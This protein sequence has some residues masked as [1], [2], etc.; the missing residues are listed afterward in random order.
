MLDFGSG[1]KPLW[2]QVADIIRDKIKN[3]EYK[4]GEILPPEMKLVDE[5]GV[6]RVTIR[7]ALDS[8]MNEGY[9]IRNRGKGTTVLSKEEVST[10]M[11]SSFSGLEERGLK[12]K[13]RL[14]DV[15]M[16]KPSKEIA[17]FFKISKEDYIIELKRAIEV[18]SKVVAVFFSYI[19]PIIPL[20]M[21]DNFKGSF[22]TLLDEKGYKVTSGKEIISATISD[23]E[24][25]KMF[26]IDIDKAIVTR[27]K[28]GFSNDIPVELTFSR[29]IADGYNIEIDLN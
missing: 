6:S 22:Y 26:D 17:N 18:N 2:S 13:K 20:T 7:Q 29:Y 16:I 23:D 3:N 19:N 15:N 11:K 27:K 5:F 25:K 4:V 21:K 14:I 1:A 9:I 28:Y 10:N 12:A 8:L 24:D